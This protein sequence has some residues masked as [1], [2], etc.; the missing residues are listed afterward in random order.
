MFDS[1]VQ[2]IIQG[3]TEFLPVSSSG[4]LALYQYFTGSQNGE[5]NLLTD[6]A[7][8]FGTL[9]AVVYYFRKD[10]MPFFTVSGWKE[11]TNR[12]LAALIVCSSIPTALIGLGFKKSFEKIAENPSIVALCLFLTGLVLLISEK[13][14]KKLSEEQK[15]EINALSLAKAFF[16]GI[17]QGIAV[18]PGISRSG[19]TITACLF[20]KLKSEDAAKY[21]FLLMIP[22]VGGATLLE[23]LKIFKSGFPSELNPWALLVGIIASGITGFLSLK[24]LV[25]IIKKQKLAIFSY[26]LFVVSIASLIA[27]HIK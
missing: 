13:I 6:I 10:L 20:S 24:F 21:S 17:A 19:S 2:G 22:A 27:I 16:I 18:T 15:D 3:L 12:R 14:G 8:H 1:I 11:Q 23:V 4:H 25:F 5:L 9:I 7:L 26:Y